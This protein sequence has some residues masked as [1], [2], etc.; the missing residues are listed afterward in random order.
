MP[1]PALPIPATC[2]LEYV[3]AS[4]CQ[5]LLRNKA[6]PIVGQSINAPV[7]LHDHFNHP[8]HWP[9]VGDNTPPQ[10][11]FNLSKILEEQQLGSADTGSS[12][13]GALN[14]TWLAPEVV[15]GD[16]ATAKS[17]VYAFGIVMYEAR[18]FI[19][20][21]LA[22]QSSLERTLSSPGAERNTKAWLECLWRAWTGGRAADQG[23]MPS[24]V[25]ATVA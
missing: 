15:R 8:L 9:V 6:C 11:D 2:G 1:L 22:Y 7:P 4:L 16:R 19:A 21:V 25:A 13:A 24:I 3:P 10:G 20:A 18:A 5:P 14:P 17:D 23:C 12:M